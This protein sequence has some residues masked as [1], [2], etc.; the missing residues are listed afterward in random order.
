MKISSE[1]WARRGLEGLWVAFWVVVVM[2]VGSC[3][4][5]VILEDEKTRQI[6]MILELEK[7][8]G[9]QLEEGT[10]GKMGPKLT[11]D[12][13]DTVPS[14]GTLGKKSAKKSEVEF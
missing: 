6:E 9:T 8:R 12:I 1:F 4:R 14:Y 5:A 7:L 13:P 3:M 2:Q 10:R 11:P